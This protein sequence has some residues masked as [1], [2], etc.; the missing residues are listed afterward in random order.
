MLE[1][2]PNLQLHRLTKDEA[3]LIHLFRVASAQDKA[4]IR[5]LAETAARP[6]AESLPAT[7]IPFR[8]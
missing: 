1:A 7:V 8:L 3:D 5:R 4:L 2:V 6:S